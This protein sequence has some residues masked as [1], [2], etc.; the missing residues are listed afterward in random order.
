MRT[1]ILISLATLFTLPFAA[2]AE[3]YTWKD[4]S[5]KTIYSDRPPLEKKAKPREVET[6]GKGGAAAPA[7]P[8][9][10]AAAAKAPEGANGGAAA[11]KN[12]DQTQA[13]AEAR[14]K[15]CDNARKR[16]IQLESEKGILVT[17]DAQG[18]DMPLVGDARKAEADAARNDV[19]TW[20]K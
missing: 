12:P 8:A 18:K 2:G 5:G 1:P 3:V 14:Q 4:A 6:T 16:L 11:A 15:L 19:D 20:C 10:G 13:E 17:K 7:K 9:E